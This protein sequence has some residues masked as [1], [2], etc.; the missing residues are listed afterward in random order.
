MVKLLDTYLKELELMKQEN[1]LDFLNKLFEENKSTPACV[2]AIDMALLE[3]FFGEGNLLGVLELDSVGEM[4]ESSFTIGLSS[5]AE[6]E[7]KLKESEEVSYFKLKIDEENYKWILEDF[8]KFTDKTFVI[9]ANQGFKSYEEAKRCAEM[10][11]EKGVAYF[12]QPFVKTNFDWH[13]RLKS[14]N[15]LPII[16]DESFQN[17]H[18]LEKIKSSFDGVN[19]KLMKCGGLLQ[20]SKII[21]KSRD[22]ELKIVFGCMSDSIIGIQHAQKLAH[23]VDWVDLDGHLLNK[24]NPSRAFL[25]T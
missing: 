16:A 23:L 17:Y 19:I 21:K 6:F 22:L 1:V 7:K 11:F 20:A 8:S 3:C 2:A 18:D 9:D 24:N 25:L 14:E 10:A 5:R 13:L 15:I 12:E 4:P